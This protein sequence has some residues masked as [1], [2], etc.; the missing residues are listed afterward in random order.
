MFIVFVNKTVGRIQIF[1]VC[2]EERYVISAIVL[3]GD[4]DDRDFML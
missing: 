4:N 2:L 1:T 3:C